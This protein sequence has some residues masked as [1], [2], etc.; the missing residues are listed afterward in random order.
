MSFVKKKQK[1][2]FSILFSAQNVFVFLLVLLLSLFPFNYAGIA[3]LLMYAP[4][5]FI[6]VIQGISICSK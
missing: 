2:R 1:K 5:S 6:I 4:F 3:Y